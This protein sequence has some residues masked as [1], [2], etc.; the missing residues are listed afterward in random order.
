MGYRKEAGV[1]SEDKIAIGRRGHPG[2]RIESFSNKYVH[3]L[4]LHKLHLTLHLYLA[5]DGLVTSSS[6]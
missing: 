3:V 2:L 1:L 5:L 4:S 6:I